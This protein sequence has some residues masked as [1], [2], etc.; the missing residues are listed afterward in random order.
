MGRV[1]ISY[2]AEDAGIV[3]EIASGLEIAGY[4]T[5]YFEHNVV[6]GSSYVK[7]I[8]QALEEC[9]AFVLVA[10][11]RSVSS[12]Q[13]TK[14]VMGAF[15]RGKPF[16]P[17][18]VEL[19][20]SKLKQLQ[21]EWRHAIGVTSMI[22]MG[23]EGVPGCCTRIVDGLKALGIK[24]EPTA[25]TLSRATPKHLADKIL[26]AGPS[27]EGERK[28]V[29]ALFAGVSGF[30]RLSQGLD[31]EEAQDLI[32]QCLDI[33]TEQVHCYEGT[34]TQLLR[35]V[36]MAL[37]G[38]PLAHED[39]PQRAL[40][41]ALA[42]RADLS[43]Y[44]GRLK[45]DNIEFETR[46]GVNTGLVVVGKIGDDLTTEYTAVGDTVDLASAMEAEAQ[47]N[48]I[49]VAENTY[50]LTEG[51]FEFQPLGKMKVKGKKEPVE[52]YQLIEAGDVATRF[53]AAVARG[54]TRFVGRE[55]EVASL[56][57]AFEKA[58]A[59]SGQVIGI[60]GEPGVGK[61]RL[62][63]HLRTM[64]PQGEYTYLEGH[65]LHYGGSMALLPFLDVLRSYFN[66]REDEQEY[67]IKKNMAARVSQLDEELKDI[68]PALED[69]FS[70]KV[71]D[72]NYL[73]L[74]P[75]LRRA[76]IFDSI[77]N[78]LVRESQ[79]RPLVLV[80]EDLHWIDSSSEE[81]LGYLIGGLAST[82]ILL[83]ILYRPE[84][85]HQWGSKTYYNQIRVD[86]LS[87]ETS[88]EMVQAI[89]K[90]GRAAQD[91]TNLILD[92]AAGNPLFMEELT[93][94]LLENGFIQKT[95]HQYVLNRKLSE[96]QVPDTLQGIIAARM[97]RLEENLK[98]TMQV[99]SVIGRDFAYRLLQSIAGMQQELKSHLLNLQ[100]LEF[101]YE[102]S[103][104]PELE[105]IFKHALTQEVA[106]NSLLL[107]RRK[108]IHDRI[109][110]AIEELYADRLEEFYE[111]LAHHY[112]R[113]ESLDKAYHYL[114]LSG[115]KATRNYARYEALAFYQGA[116]D[117][118]KKQPDT[119]ENKRRGI[120][121]RLLMSIPMRALSYPEGSLPVLEEGERLAREMGDE[122]S[123][124]QFLGGISFYYT[125][126]GDP[127]NGLK[128]AEDCFREAEKVQD[129]DLV[130]PIGFQICNSYPT[131]GAFWKEAEVAP[132]V[133]ALIES[134]GTQL[135]PFGLGFNVY[136]GLQSTY[137]AALSALGDF[138]Q[139]EAMCEKSLRFAQEIKDRTCIA[140]VEMCYAAAYYFK[141]DGEKTVAFAQRA[142]EHIEETQ[143]LTILGFTWQV[144]AWG[145]MLRG[146]LDTA[147][148]CAEK[149]DA[150]NCALG[151]SAYA[152]QHFH[153]MTEICL[154]LR[155]WEN[156][157]R[158][159]EEG[160]KIA[161]SHGLRAHE[162]LLNIL[163]GKALAR[164]KHSRSVSPEELIL[165]GISILEELKLKPYQAEGYLYLGE[166]Y[167]DM[168]QREKASET[169]KKAEDAFRKM[170]MDYWL[171]MTQ[172]IMA[173]L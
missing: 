145:H 92:R 15:E 78:L 132:R 113:A 125:L 160:L 4:R 73:K 157:L 133:L 74:E 90:E 84:Y 137:G 122:R 118:L 108:E 42:I 29:T 91:L 142:I 17:I 81:F 18:L 98:R 86:E 135:E 168:S 31:P 167:T 8:S 144:L 150:H 6:S 110:K 56:K 7:Q 47:P 27:M 64:L 127:E 24:P 69:I 156:A 136:A 148:E 83:I 151:F 1:F 3:R 2:V 43:E 166:L 140:M 172:E 124:A 169:L 130:A 170:G 72:E 116:L 161:K 149:G 163:L 13:V 99:A 33:V 75:A 36:V 11:P 143:L 5:W 77:K 94:S 63:L 117:L 155:D 141:G 128:Y 48:T 68:L 123:L 147:R 22:I 62:L 93:H 10:S 158:Y 50:R 154:D 115:D 30:T 49:Q 152:A 114:K 101:I 112:S 39:A 35:N 109:G 45:K 107:K 103:L 52:A 14:E 111:V 57:E 51:F 138:E 139:G 96:I 120:E 32:R 67:I 19:R 34:V 165:Q 104:F 40:Y 131:T 70:L 80:I 129:V 26:A 95:D 89:L 159:A 102:K 134:T 61:S 58:R 53:E 37:F 100:E 66:I 23:P 12:E 126:K 85:T 82:H 20:P 76:R 25:S 164:A 171:R 71:E 55:K 46:I 60:V 97:D 105:Y 59:G 65:C 119:E 121:I 79:N 16:F 9:Q 54:L 44:A 28:Q 88:A 38:A 41:A 146:E 173:K 106:Y 162:G 153:L 87:Q 21:P